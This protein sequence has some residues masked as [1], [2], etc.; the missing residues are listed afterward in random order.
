MVQGGDDI[1]WTGVRSGCQEG[2][3]R[4]NTISDVWFR[5][6]MTSTGLVSEVGVRRVV[7]VSI[8]YQII[9]WHA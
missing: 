5:A 4:L 6:V 3:K 1:Y 2:G 8:Q 9:R 7:N